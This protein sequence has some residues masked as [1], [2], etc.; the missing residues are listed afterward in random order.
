[1]ETVTKKWHNQ[2]SLVGHVSS[3][4]GIG[5][6]ADKSIKR[7]LSKFTIGYIFVFLFAICV[8]YKNN[9]A[10]CKSHLAL[11]SILSI[12]MAVVTAF[13][14][15]A[16]AGVEINFVVKALPFIL[17][18]LGIDDTFV[19]MGAYHSTSM[20]LSVE[21]RIAQ[22]M[23]RAVSM[24]H[25]IV[26]CI[27][28]DLLR[29]SAVCIGYNILLHIAC[30]FECVLSLCISLHEQYIPSLVFTPQGSSIL[31]TS[32]T[33]MMVFLV[34]TYTDLPAMK[35]FSIYAF[36][37]IAFDFIYQVT[38]FTA[39]VV[40]DAQREKRAMQGVG[41]GGLS[42]CS[43]RADTKSEATTKVQC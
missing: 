16:L 15:A 6:E 34:G 14:I 22:T 36:L 24:L 7:D 5:Y 38:F 41:F 37:G 39:F 33:D 20:D 31:V 43:N 12:V 32:I 40:L 17:L 11:I 42:C 3:F 26:Q 2:N 19:I 4:E 8:L 28:L 18:G 1:M 9:S 25:V 21:D 29:N 23:S 27:R 30:T 10:A 13:G 35:A